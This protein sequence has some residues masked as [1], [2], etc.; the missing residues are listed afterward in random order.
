MDLTDNKILFQTVLDST[1]YGIA[2][3]QTVYTDEKAIDFSILLLNKAALSQIG[4]ATYKGKRYTDVF[5]L[6]RNTD[7]PKKFTEVAETGVTANF[8]Q[9]F[10]DGAKSCF[11]FTVVKQDELLVVTTE[12]ITESKQTVLALN[13]ALKTAEKQKRLYDSITSNT[14]DLVYVFNPEY[15]FIY[16]NKALLAMWGKT[17]EAAIGR[18]LRENGYEEWHA[19][20]HE[21]EIDEVIATKKTIRGTV[22]FPHAE[23]GSRVYD[24]IF[25]PV[26]N[27]NGEVEAIAGITRDITEIKQAETSLKERESHLRALINASSDVIYSLNADWTVMNPMDGR[28]FLVDASA[29]VENWMEINV[30]PEDREA[31]KKAIAAAIAT[32]SIFEMEHR[33]LTVNGS[34]GW[35]FSRAVPILDDDKNITEWFGAASDIT[36]RK[37][38]EQSLKLSES[39]FRGLADG[40]P[41]FVFIIE[42]D[43]LAP[44][45]YWNKAWLDYTGQNMEEAVDRAWDGIIHPDDVPIVMNF[46]GAAFTSRKP[47]FIPAV[48]T[49]RHDGVYR[50][51]TFKG[52]PRYLP[53]GSF[54]GYVGVGFDVHEQKITEERLEF[55]VSERTRELQRSNEDLQQFAHVASH[56][57]KEPVRKVK[58]FASRLEDHLQNKLDEKAA[59]F[60]ERIHVATDRM[61]T[62]I[63]GVLTYSTI[64]EGMQQPESV[65]LN[66][67]LKNIETDLEVALQQTGGSI[68]YTNLPELEGAQVLLYQLFY[69]LINNSIKFAKADSTPRITI[70]SEIITENDSRF[71]HILL[72]DNG[73]GFEQ[74]QAEQ[75]FET[76][77]RLNPKDKY[78]G[79]GLGL[80]LCKKI[81][82]RHGGAITASSADDDGALFTI[83]LPL[84]QTGK[85][86]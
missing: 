66:E 2:V 44:V 8:E 24:Y 21:R 29:P 59:K 60:I 35:T 14:P 31:V 7:I 75:I 11:R 43:S 47:Y 86:I 32:K 38:M 64:N 4:D 46:Y 84:K 79:T 15:R 26:V 76:F 81:V 36:V 85:G 70:S 37:E 55:L 77:T 30:Y 42:P 54:N 56:D 22:S 18:G 63:D 1:A 51:H 68:H 49:K 69:N 72:K 67:V 80:S 52:N 41:M 83:T 20:M 78:E 25:G 5:P 50:W 12:D 23:L 34:P 71:A 17:E 6:S 58:T 82:A 9:W 48:R 28:G 16:A 39:R 53:D 10:D 73:I 61:F 40:S 65:D 3:L 27:E 45:S 13:N 57:L 62:M 19:Q 33:V 74:S